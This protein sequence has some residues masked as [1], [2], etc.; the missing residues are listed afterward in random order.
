[1]EINNYKRR[2]KEDGYKHKKGQTGK[3]WEGIE[4]QFPISSP[5]FK[6]GIPGGVK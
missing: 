5:V 2:R 1:L 6:R 4:V 3:I